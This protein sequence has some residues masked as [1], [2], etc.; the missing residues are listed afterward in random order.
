[1]KIISRTKKKYTRARRGGRG[2]VWGGDKQVEEEA[3]VKE[4]DGG[5]K[6]AEKEGFDGVRD[7]EED[8]KKVEDEER[9]KG[10]FGDKEECDKSEGIGENE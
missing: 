4:K 8:K 6:R 9:V 2:E 7:K 3:K 1:M 10:E 5:T